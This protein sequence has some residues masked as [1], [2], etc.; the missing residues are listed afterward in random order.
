M[1]DLTGRVF[2]RLIV[3][4]RVKIGGKSLW[5]CECTC[6][7]KNRNIVYVATSHLK[8]GNTKSCGCLA[9]EVRMLNGE[10]RK[11][12]L[13]GQRF[14]RLIAKRIIPEI[15]SKSP[16]WECFCDCNNICYVTAQSLKSG[17]TRSCGCLLED[18]LKKMGKDSWEKILKKKYIGGTIID[19]LLNP[20]KIRSDNTCGYPGI[21]ERKR[22]GK[23]VAKLT[24]C[25]KSY[26]LG[27][28]Y[29]KSEAILAR[30]NA[31][32]ELIEA[33]M[34]QLKEDDLTKF[35]EFKQI[36]KENQDRKRE[37]LKLV[38]ESEIKKNDLSNKRFG[39][40]TVLN[41]IGEYRNNEKIWECRCECEN[42][43]FYTTSELINKG[44]VSCNEDA[45]D[46]STDD[47]SDNNR[48]FTWDKSKRKWAVTTSMQHKP[49]LICRT[50]NIEYAKYL[51]S[52]VRRQ[53]RKGD[54][55]E[56]FINFKD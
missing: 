4:E 35:L 36:M 33:F 40:L 14:G 46:C 34:R 32:D 41:D 25:G 31:E 26:W 10:R 23:W 38:I 2:D 51:S 17:S 42:I 44:F 1:D 56:W 39:K 16:T 7:D 45:I 11:E 29:S 55:I 54:F 13:T 27:S 47:K 8:S 22:D 9:K 37:E 3:L 50:E 19:F 49:Y 24:F 18:N 12:D 43:V 53:K 30:M 5:K 48:G 52:V 6:K 20:G 21:E 28:F 15:K